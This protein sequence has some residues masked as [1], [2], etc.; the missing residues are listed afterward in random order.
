V[1]A[2]VLY[3]LARVPRSRSRSPQRAV[4]FDWAGQVTAVPGMGT[5]IYGLIEG[6]AEGFD[7]P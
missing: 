7:A 5:L 3:L 1:G 4:P 6:G 2:V